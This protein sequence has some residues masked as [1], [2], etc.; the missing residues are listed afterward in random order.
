MSNKF[1]CLLGIHER[2]T[3]DIYEYIDF[4]YERKVPSYQLSWRCKICGK[5]DTE[6][7]YN[8]SFSDKSNVISKPTQTTKEKI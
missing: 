1:W 8:R 3:L 6:V 5:I 4:S 2:E 7:H